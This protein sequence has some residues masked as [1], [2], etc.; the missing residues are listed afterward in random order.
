MPGTPK[1]KEI[2]QLNDR[3]TQSYER[4]N[5]A[6]LRQFI[7]NAHIHD[8]AFGSKLTKDEFLKDVESGLLE[9]ISYKTPFIEWLR[10]GNITIVREV[11]EAVAKRSGKVFPPKCFRL[12]RIFR[13]QSEGWKVLLFQNTIMA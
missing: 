10:D 2:E 11:V 5:V 13:R 1:I 4:D 3:L 9:F 8:N 7:S 12:T 6:T